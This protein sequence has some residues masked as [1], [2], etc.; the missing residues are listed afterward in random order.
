MKLLDRL[1]DNLIAQ[2][3]TI[4]AKSAFAPE[5]ALSH[6]FEKCEIAVLPIP[7][8]KTST[9]HKGADRGPEAMLEASQSVELYDI[10][11]ASEVYRRGIYTLS[12][13]VVSDSPEALFEKA[14]EVVSSLCARK[15]FPVILGGEHSISA[16]VVAGIA[17]S[18]S[19]LSVLQL[20]A[21]GDTRESYMGS[22]FNHACVMARVREICP[23]VQ[24]GIRAIDISEVAALNRERVF[25]A[26]AIH[27]ASNDLA[28]QNQAISLLSPNVYV[29]IDLD[30]FDSSIMPSTGTPEPGGLTWQQVTT[31]LKL[32][33]AKRSIVGFDVVEL[34]PRESN[35]APD[36]LAAK[37]VYQFLS[38]I[39]AQ[40]CL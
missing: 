16:G 29:T 10:E 18:C 26:H 2:H 19:N 13:L 36:F 35:P 6:D 9:Y 3:S 1:L 7:Y 25:F 4:A 8:D 11:T 23:I 37:L 21:H 17:N 27:A 38:Y 14:K 20:D 22:R 30:C 33:A 34:L 32:L 40:K 15:K 5:E 12:P 28:W 31:F 24:V 39:F